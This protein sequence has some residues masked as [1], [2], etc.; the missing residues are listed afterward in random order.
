MIVCLQMKQFITKKE[1]KLQK[2]FIQMQKRLYDTKQIIEISLT[3]HHSFGM[4]FAIFHPGQPI[5]NT[6]SNFVGAAKNT[7]VKVIASFDSISQP[8]FLFLNSILQ[9]KNK[10]K[11]SEVIRHHIAMRDV[12][13][14]PH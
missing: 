11:I 14:L 2:W 9:S 13:P 5:F 3:L 6:F 4:N 8:H 7:Q 12:H 10:I 1:K